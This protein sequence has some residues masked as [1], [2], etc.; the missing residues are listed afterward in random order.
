MK[1][2]LYKDMEFAGRSIKVEWY[3]MLYGFKKK[4]RGIA[5]EPTTRSRAD[6]RNWAK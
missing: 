6:A 3:K 5:I 1:I 4:N 2:M